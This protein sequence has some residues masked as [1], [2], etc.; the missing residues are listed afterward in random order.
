MRA[1]CGARIAEKL[2]RYEGHTVTVLDEPKLIDL[3]Q[4]RDRD[5]DFDH[6][7][8]REVNAREWIG[9]TAQKLESQ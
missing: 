8:L 4:F 9:A 5:G 7:W 1:G 3:S 2:I 6:D